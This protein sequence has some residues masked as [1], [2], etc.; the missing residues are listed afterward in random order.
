LGT[1]K[2]CVFG[3]R[4]STGGKIFSLL[5]FKG[6]IY[7]FSL[8][9]LLYLK[10]CIV[11][12]FLPRSLLFLPCSALAS[13]LSFHCSRERDSILEIPVTSRICDGIKYFLASKMASY[14]SFQCLYNLELLSMSSFE[15]GHF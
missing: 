12:I 5:A 7:V 4:E 15:I 13:C 3:N 10:L 1:R 14:G 9:F 8:V 6:F 2:K 11:I